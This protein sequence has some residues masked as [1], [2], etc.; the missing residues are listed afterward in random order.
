MLGAALM[1]RIV[2]A[3]WGPCSSPPGSNVGDCAAGHR[4]LSTRLLVVHILPAVVGLLIFVAYALT[5]VSALAWCSCAI[6]VFV[7]DWGVR[8]FLLG[9]R[10]RLGVLRATAAAWKVPPTIAA[11]HHLPPELHFPVAV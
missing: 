3:G 4:R 2:T 11:D 5:D 9:Q 1:A 10:R 7:A 8:N 6:L